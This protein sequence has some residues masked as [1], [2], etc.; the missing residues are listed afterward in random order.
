MGIAEKR[1]RDGETGTENQEY[2]NINEETEA[3]V[4]SEEE[5]GRGETGVENGG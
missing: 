5:R 1:N 2:M 3:T 4:T